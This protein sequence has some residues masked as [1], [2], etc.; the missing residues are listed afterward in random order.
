MLG[1][2]DLQ[3]VKF[4][5]HGLVPWI[6]VRIRIHRPENVHIYCFL[7]TYFPKWPLK[8]CSILWNE[9]FSIVYLYFGL[10]DNSCVND[11][12]EKVNE[13]KK[14]FWALIIGKF[15]CRVCYRDYK[16]MNHY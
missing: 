8:F 7:M 15:M 3:V 4:A 13:V 6:M 14:R 16:F 12:S 11:L 5:N 10:F 2:L 1:C 9:Q